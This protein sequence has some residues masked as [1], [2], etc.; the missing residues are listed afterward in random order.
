V[1]IIC[2]TPRFQARW[3]RIPEPRLLLQSQAQKGNAAF[4]GA[5]L[6]VGPNQQFGSAPGGIAGTS[7][8]IQAPQAPQAPQVPQVP[9]YP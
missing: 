4:P 2:Y 5:A 1:I 8:P 9:I 7:T 6:S 3:T